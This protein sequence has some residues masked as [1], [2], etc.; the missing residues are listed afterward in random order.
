MSVARTTVPSVK[1]VVKVRVLPTDEQAPA[2]RETIDTCNHAASWLS[3]RMHGARLHRKHDVQKFFYA[4]LRVHFG[5]SAQSAIRVIAK[6]ADAYDALRANLAAGN[7][8]PPGSERRRKIEG[9]PVVFRPLAAQPFDARCLSWQFPDEVVRA[10]TVSIRTVAGRLKNVPILGNPKQLMLL[11]THVIGETDLIC[12]DGKW[13][14]HATVEV[15]EPRVASPR[16]GSW[17]WTWASSTS[18]LRVPVRRPPVPGSTA[19][20]SGRLGCGN[21]CRPR[22]PAPPAGC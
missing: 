2:L 9:L 22:N 3:R 18:R 11:R 21:D 20:A 13:F 5:L 8:G 19:T 16:T 12:R 7:Y 6:V 15:P 4:E 1:Q 17:A 14:L 10:A